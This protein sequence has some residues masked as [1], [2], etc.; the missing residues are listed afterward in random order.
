M[1][2]I[3][4]LSTLLALATVTVMAQQTTRPTVVKPTAVKNTPA[5]VLK[6]PEPSKGIVT[7][8]PPPSTPTN[9]PPAP[10]PAP[11]QSSTVVEY[12]LTKVR[13]RITTGRDNKESPSEVYTKFSLPEQYA[14]SYCA[15]AQWNMQNEMPVNDYIEVGLNKHANANL[16][17][18]STKLTMSNPE[19]LKTGGKDILL[20]DIQKYGGRLMIKYYPHLFTDAWRIENVTLMLEFRDKNDNLHPVHGSKTL[21][22]ANA[23]TFLNAGNERYLICEVGTD[24]SAMVSYTKN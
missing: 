20:S 17:L 4:L 23:K 13:V 10:A 19:Q 9:P 21:S 1:K 18:I 6:A 8:P 15:F 16:S 11:A 24:L 12:K 2:R 22:F 7:T 5:P 14:S 3:V